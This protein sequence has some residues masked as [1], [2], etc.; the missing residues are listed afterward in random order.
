[1][2]PNYNGQTFIFRKWVP[3]QLST[4]LMMKGREKII[5]QKKKKKL[6]KKIMAIGYR[7]Q[8]AVVWES[9]HALLPVQTI[10]SS[11]RYNNLGIRIPFMYQVNYLY[12]SLQLSFNF[13]F[14]IC[15]WK[16]T[17]W[18]Q[19]ISSRKRKSRIRRCWFLYLNQL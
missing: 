7:R 5:F 18:N 19:V 17:E 3:I 13:Q 11:Q 9:L 4:S 10:G 6:K 15:L 14:Y 12:A 2:I 16:T 8:E 1:M